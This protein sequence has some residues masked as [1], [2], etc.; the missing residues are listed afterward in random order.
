MSLTESTTTLDTAWTEQDITVFTAGLLS[1][2]DAM[3]TEVQ[4]KLARGA[5]DA[6]ST[7]TA[8]DVKRW[9]GRAKQELAELKNYSFKRR[10]AYASTVADTYRYSLPPDYNGGDLTLRDTSNDRFIKFWDT[11]LFDKR[12]PDPGAETADKPLVAT[13]KNGE[14]WIIPPAGGV[15]TLEAEYGRSG[16]DITANDFAWLPEIERFRCCDFAIAESF[17]AL[18]ML[19]YATAYRSK[20]NGGLQKAIRADGRRKWASMRYQAI[21]I[22]QEKTVL[23][24]QPT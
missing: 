1:D 2:A 10:Y 24:N 17:E 22:F 23:D 5:I 16:D 21:S 20:W 18:H 19:D 15:Y 14:L 6:N 7:P 12:Y 3:V 13:I 9:L 8:T 4:S 11:K